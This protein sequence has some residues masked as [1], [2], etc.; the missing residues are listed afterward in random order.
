MRAEAVGLLLVDKPE[1]PTSHDMVDIVRRAT[2]VRRVGHTG[3]LDPFAS[4]LLLLCVG[5]VTRLAE[6]LIPLP[7]VYRGVI[8][9]GE[10]TDSDDRTG[11]VVGRSED[12]HGLDEASVR[13]ALGEVVGEIEQVPPAFS[14]KKLSG[15]RAY[16]VARGGEDVS[17]EPQLVTVRSI[18]LRDLSL[19]DVCIVIACSGGTYV[20]AIARDVGDA[21]GVGGHLAELRRLRIGEFSVDDALRLDRDTPAA[22]VHARLRR[23]EEAVRALERLDLDLEVAE[24]LRHGRPAIWSRGRLAGP[25]AAFVDDSLVAIVEQRENRIWPRKVFGAPSD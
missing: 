2:G 14:A 4:G 23:P 22:E 13:R 6:Y 18:E 12:W 1:G 17:L 24:A 19:P 21:L 9:L 8:R 16:D 15:R 3:T 25:A 20:R 5:W 11:T 7:K 10:R